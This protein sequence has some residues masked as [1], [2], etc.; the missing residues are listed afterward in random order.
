MLPA[1][2]DLNDPY[3]TEFFTYKGKAMAL[4]RQKAISIFELPEHILSVIRKE[5]KR[6][7]LQMKKLGLSKIQDENEKLEKYIIA[8][9]GKFDNI[10]DFDNGTTN[11]ELEG[12]DAITHYKLSKKEVEFLKLLAQSNSTQEVA[13]KMFISPGTA[14]VHSHH[15]KK[16][17]GVKSQIEMI[18][19]AIKYEIAE[20]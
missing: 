5:M 16:K 12:T 14:E 15:I 7:P 11:M 19:F 13:R 6:W 18:R 8:N 20:L 10:P 9:Y 2:L 3:R 1:G 17:I 4:Y